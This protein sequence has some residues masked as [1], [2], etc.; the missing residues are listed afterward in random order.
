MTFPRVE[1]ERLICM[2]SFR[3][4]PVAFVL[5]CLSEPWGGGERRWEAHMGP[6]MGL[7]RRREKVGG[8]YGPWYGAGEE[9][10]EGGRHIWA[11]V[12]GWGGGERRWEAHMGPGMG[13]GRRRGKVGGTYGPW[14]G[15]GEEGP[16]VGVGVQQGQQGAA[17]PS[18]GVAGGLGPRHCAQQ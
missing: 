1:R 16:G 18:S 8:T 7:G 3:R 10:R 15:A 2:A 11:L 14:C 6:G 5:V 12:W 13:L 17:C 4:S 9:E